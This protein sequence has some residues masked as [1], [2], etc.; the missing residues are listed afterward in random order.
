M[1]TIKSREIVKIGEANAEQKR[2]GLAF[3]HAVYELMKTKSIDLAY[4]RFVEEF[5]RPSKGALIRLR[6]LQPIVYNIVEAVP[7][8]P[9]QLTIR[10]TIL[11]VQADFIVTY[12]DGRKEIWELK[13]HA[14][15]ESE[16]QLK[17]EWLFNAKLARYLYRIY[18]YDYPVALVYYTMRS[19]RL[20]IETE[21]IYHIDDHILDILI[22][23]IVT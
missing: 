6:L 13:S 12:N 11:S 5:G 4:K 3:E 8:P 22:S 2:Y 15:K 10:S 19:G 17:S 18:G 7:A 20:E 14:L 1:R 21:Q 9:V 23:R 16:V